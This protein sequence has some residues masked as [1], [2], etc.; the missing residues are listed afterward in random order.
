MH[1]ALTL[2]GF[3]LKETHNLI[4]VVWRMYLSEKPFNASILSYDN[5]EHW[6][7]DMF[8]QSI[9][10]RKPIEYAEWAQ[11]C[12]ILLVRFERCRSVKGFTPKEFENWRGEY[13]S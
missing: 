5:L 8:L 1:S 13:I 3:S 6:I 4:Y 10:Q 11:I 12:E 9:D 2:D 7:E